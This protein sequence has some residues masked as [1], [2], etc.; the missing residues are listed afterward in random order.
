MHMRAVGQCIYLLMM[1]LI[2]RIRENH[3]PMESTLPHGVSKD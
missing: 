1:C 3:Y 2:I